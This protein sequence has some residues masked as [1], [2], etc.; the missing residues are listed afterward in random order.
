V[1]KFSKTVMAAAVAAGLGMGVSTAARADALSTSIL[2][3]SNLTFNDPGTGT[4]IANGANVIVTSVT[5]TARATST[6]NGSTMDTGLVSTGGGGI[7]LAP[8]CLGGAA[9]T[10]PRVQDNVFGVFSTA[11]GDPVKTLSTADQRE[12]GSPILGLA[13]PVGATVEASSITSLKGSGSGDAHAQNGVIAQFVFQVTSTGK[14]DIKFNAQSYLEAFVTPFFGTGFA[15]ST[16]ATSF[17]LCEN[18]GTSCVQIFS[19][20]PDGSAGGITGGTELLDPFNLNT[21]VASQS[22]FGGA[23]IEGAAP[24]V[25]NSGTFEA[26]TGTL[27]AGHTYTLNMA[28]STD[29]AARFIPEPA[30]LGLIA[31]GLLGIGGMQRR[32]KSS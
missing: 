3:L 17:K 5:E 9:C 15:Q 25:K 23:S 30:T 31:I 13:A 22:P 7:N 11:A 2:Q 32:R 29:S 24:G 19:W 14:I 1:N 26:L 20:A 6:L 21:T 4:P 16:F 18:L 12:A 27:L 10:D 8:Q 28:M